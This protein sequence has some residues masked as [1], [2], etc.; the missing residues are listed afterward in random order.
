MLIELV[1]SGLLRA[2]VVASFGV[3][4]V[5]ALRKPTARLWGADAAWRLWRVVPA[6]VVA[7]F[8][9]GPAGWSGTGLELPSAAGGSLGEGA[10][11][12]VISVWGA[13]VLVSTLVVLLQ[14]RAFR[15]S[16]SRGVA[17]P[18]VMGA[19]WPRLVTPHDFAQRFTPRQRALIL[20]HERAHIARG[21]VQAAVLITA[22]RT[23]FWFNPLAYV[24]AKLA[25]LDQ[26]LACDAEVL[27]RDPAAR[28]DY[29]EALLCAQL[30]GGG[31]GAASCGWLARP[32]L[33]VRLRALLRIPPPAPDSAMCTAG[34]PL[35]MALAVWAA[36]PTGE[37]RAE[38]YWPA[39]SSLVDIG[40]THAKD[41]STV[42]VVVRTP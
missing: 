20:A 36:E 33:E 13:G 3:L 28:R 15:R 30:R 14:D 2:T 27:A 31:Q 5:V 12:A 7:S 26:E 8:F 21:D 4:A 16:A 40:L 35:L 38:T 10:S 39:A 37:R 24:A 22:C 19:F 29:A 42:E 18:A 25:R 17:G 41:A 6:A 1:A 11:L 23:L 34:A 9:P 32:A